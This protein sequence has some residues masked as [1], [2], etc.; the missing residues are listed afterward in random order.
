MST[1]FENNIW[2]VIL[3]FAVAVIAWLSCSKMNNIRIRRATRATIIF[4]VIPIF[5]LGH[6]FLFYQVWV[7]IVASVVNSEF[8]WLLIYLVAWSVFLGFS[9]IGIKNGS[10][11][12]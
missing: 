5:Y 2:L 10:K 6:P 3:S 12:I 7:L 1:F 8:M 9:Q 4:L 11:T